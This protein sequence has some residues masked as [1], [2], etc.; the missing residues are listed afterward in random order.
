MAAVERV[1]LGRT[2]ER[3]SAI[4]LGTWQW[5]SPAWGWPHGYRESDVDEAFE[6]AL[7]LGIN[8]FDTAEIYGGG[9]SEDLL[10]RALRGRRDQVFIATKLFPSRITEAAVRRAALASLRRLRVD[11][12]DLYQLHFP[13]PFVPTGRIVRAMER[14]VK[15]GKVRYLG[16]SNLGVRGLDSARK[17]LASEDIVSDQVKYSLLHRAPERA[18]LPYARREGVTVI[19][20]SP[21]AQGALTGKYSAD[22]VPRDLVRGANRLF[23]PGN[24]RRIQAGIDLL[25]AIGSRHAKTASEVALN[26][27]R[28]E[29]TVLPIPGVKR[30]A[31]VEEAAGATGWRL[32]PEEF[33]EID[34]VFRSVHVST[35]AA[36][37]WVIGRSLRRVFSGPAK[38]Q[39]GHEDARV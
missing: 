18:L 28:R 14:L 4:G 22:R 5:G 15:E 32:S 26:W 20:Y 16:V 38:K 1:E 37:P 12:I 25:N 8:F 36:I 30:A 24:L 35:A 21:L 13:N 29:P 23:A 27:L 11:V 3:V 17:A 34:R 39:S 6:R 9:R 10:G 2:G 19:A 31:H 7:S 33:N